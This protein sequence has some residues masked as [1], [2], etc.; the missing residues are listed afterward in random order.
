[1][2][3][4][5]ERT[6]VGEGIDLVVEPAVHRFFR[7][8][9]YRVRGRD[10][11][12]Q[13]DF[14]T[15]L[16]S[17]S[18]AVPDEGR[19]VIALATHVHVDHVGSFHEYADRLGH[20]AEAEAFA[21]MADDGTLAHLYRAIAEP[22]AA[23]PSPGWTIADYSIA[24]APLT[25]VVGEGDTIDLGN[26]RFTV[27]HLPGHSPGSIGLLDERDGTFFSGDAIYV[28]TLVDD[29]PGSDRAVYAATMERLRRLPVGIVHGGHG[30][31]F[32]AA[33]MRAIAEAY[34]ASIGA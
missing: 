18:A 34:L 28:G 16:K 19:P 25:R 32:D 23:A 15:G 22:V 7:A 1:M 2:A 30:P 20:A 29:L 6:L 17:L 10:A 33:R 11:D 9:L 5:F 13:I 21:T 14:G 31:A 12:L 8:N 26:R 4:W 24:P 3:A 27:L